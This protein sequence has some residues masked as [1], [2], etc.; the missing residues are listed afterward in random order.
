[1]ETGASSSGWLR[2]G[3]EWG[4]R[5]RPWQALPSGSRKKDKGDG[6]VQPD[7]AAEIG[8]YPACLTVLTM[9]GGAPPPPAASQSDI[10]PPRGARHCCL[11][12]TMKAIL[13]VLLATLA[14]QPGETWAGHRAGPREQD[15]RWGRPREAGGA[16]RGAPAQRHRERSR[17]RRTGQRESRWKG[18][19]QWQEGGPLMQ[20]M[21]LR[22]SPYCHPDVETAGLGVGPHRL[23][24]QRPDSLGFNLALPRGEDGLLDGQ[25]DRQKH[26]RPAG[27]AGGAGAQSLERR[28]A[29]P[30]VTSRSIPHS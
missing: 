26:R 8:T 6:R 2:N 15:W 4:E 29:T 9:G 25:T 10:K 13:L 18:G 7:G 20:T 27:R 30:P 19:R 24:R 14:L 3:P 17:R 11:P 28:S 1:M 22:G 5:P 21:S 12:V 16:Q 23:P